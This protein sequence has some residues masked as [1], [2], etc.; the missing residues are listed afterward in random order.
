MTLRFQEPWWL[1]VAV[2]ALPMAI[3]AL[4]VFSAMSP[5]RRWSAALFRAALLVLLAAMLAGATLVKP[6]DKLAVVALVDV[7]GSVRAFVPPT[8]DGAGGGV[9]P[10]QEVAKRLAQ[11]T[12]GRGPDDLLG[13]VVFDGTATVVAAP[14][15]GDALAR[16]LDVQT[17]EGTDIAAAIRTAMLLFPP[18][19]S[20]RI[21]LISDGVQTQGDAMA[22]AREAG[23]ARATAVGGKTDGLSRATPIDVV[24][25]RYQAAREVLVES[26]DVPARAPA[27]ATIT[28]RVTLLASAPT[29]GMLR[30][31][32]EEKPVPMGGKPSQRVELKAG[33]NVVVVSVPLGPG[34]I[35]KLDALF[36]PDAPVPGQPSSD[37]LAA[38]NR[39]EAFVVTPG[40]GGVLIV[41]GVGDATSQSP[42]DVLA[43]ALRRENMRV[44]LVAPGAMPIDLLRLQAFDAVILDNVPADALGTPA[45][46]MLVRYVTEL[47]G[48][49]IMVGGPESFGAGGWKG[50]PVEPILPVKLDLPERLVIPSAAVIFVIDTSGSMGHSVLGSSRSQ[51]DIANLGAAT[52]IRSMDKSDL[53][54]LIEFNSGYNVVFNLRANTDAEANAREGLGLSPGGGTNMP[55]ALDEAYRQLKN[56]KAQNKHVIV[57]SDG[58]SRGKNRL[59]AIADAMKADGIRVSAIAV[60]DDA[61][62]DGMAILADRTGGEFFRVRD[63]NTLP[64]IFVKAVR[65]V[66]SPMIREEPFVP[67]VLA[68][69]SALVDGIDLG[70]MPPLGGLTLTQPRAGKDVAET[71]SVSYVMATAEGEPVLAHWQA[72]LG[73]V[74]A[75]TSDAHKWADKWLGWPGYA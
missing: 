69:G 30:V 64:R 13:I 67:A 14:T 4:T 45:Q 15:A 61:D 58:I 71:V 12:Q 34:R 51:Q 9:P 60:G 39:A 16:N 50:T 72:G 46:Q 20:R 29:T 37:T 56:V 52:A 23:G 33:R 7:S 27:G 70:S 18:D 65:L 54:G 40:V 75:F 41:D 55:P 22:A 3:S 10:V 66:R 21:V 25:L 42:A 28:A 49:L 48:G 47:G 26:V 35:H 8:V 31:T 32:A 38:N 43:R 5:V 63:P 17:I 11:I 62:A 59:A 44:D 74:A 2:L 57:L 53:V 19:A 68:P 73:Q 36:E 6:V 24:P 1:L